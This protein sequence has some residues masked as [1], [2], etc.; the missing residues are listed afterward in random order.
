MGIQHYM[1]K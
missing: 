1:V